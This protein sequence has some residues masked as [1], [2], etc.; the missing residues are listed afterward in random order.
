MFVRVCVCLGR[1]VFERNS[2]SLTCLRMHLCVRVQQLVSHTRCVVSGANVQQY[3]QQYVQQNVQQYGDTMFP[4][5]QQYSDMM[6][7]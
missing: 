4:L 7:K 5:F 1:N 3:V 2:F 6:Y